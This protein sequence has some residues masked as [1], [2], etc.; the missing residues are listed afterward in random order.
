MLAVD[1]AMALQL[2][3]LR[4]G[5]L[6]ETEMGEIPPKIE[7]DTEKDKRCKRKCARRAPNLA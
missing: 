6:I 7:R 2:D 4:T 5:E 1:L 3:D